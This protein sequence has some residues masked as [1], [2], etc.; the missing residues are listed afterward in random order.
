[1]TQRYSS[2]ARLKLGRTS[3]PAGLK[4]NEEVGKWL[5]GAEN[6]EVPGFEDIV[7]GYRIFQA[8]R[9]S[10]SLGRKNRRSWRIKLELEAPDPTSLW[11]KRS[12]QIYNADGNIYFDPVSR[13]CGVVAY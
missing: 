8:Q 3:R 10:T 6:T 5:G 2:A 13:R 1:V 12:T 4:L 7:A 9:V 11:R